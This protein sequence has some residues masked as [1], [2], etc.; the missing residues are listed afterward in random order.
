MRQILTGSARGY[1]EACME[2]QPRQEKGSLEAL[3]MLLTKS[4]QFMSCEQ[5]QAAPFYWDLLR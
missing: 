4:H 1:T 3:T 5:K 2:A